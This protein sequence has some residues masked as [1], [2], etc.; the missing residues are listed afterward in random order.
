MMKGIYFYHENK[1]PWGDFFS[2]LF[3]LVACLCVMP[4]A[5]NPIQPVVLAIALILDIT[6]LLYGFRAY[7]KFIRYLRSR[8]IARHI[9]AE[10]KFNEEEE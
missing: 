7:H 10:E 5:F 8:E 1:F 2:A 6:M 3:L 4:F 9:A